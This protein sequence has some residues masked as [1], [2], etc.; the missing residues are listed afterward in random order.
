MRQIDQVLATQDGCHALALC[1]DGGVL[2]YHA[3]PTSTD[4]AASMAGDSS[5]GGHSNA[6]AGDDATDWAAS[7]GSEDLQASGGSQKVKKRC[8]QLVEFQHL[9][10]EVEIGPQFMTDNAWCLKRVGRRGV[11]VLIRACQ[12][13]RGKEGCD[14]AGALIDVSL[15]S[16][17][18]IDM[19]LSVYQRIMM[20]LHFRFGA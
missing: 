19:D 4:D 12:G 6:E 5:G 15:L 16:G 9:S 7:G 18:T 8:G 3:N 13:V 10:R 2:Y 20:A 1:T 14:S 17:E 11:V